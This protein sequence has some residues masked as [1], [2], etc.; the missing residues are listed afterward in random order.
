MKIGLDEAIRVEP[1]VESRW[2]RRGTVPPTRRLPVSCQVMHH[3]YRQ[4]LTTRREPWSLQS[5]KP[6]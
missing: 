1:V 2:S 4:D 5:H 3:K 6:K